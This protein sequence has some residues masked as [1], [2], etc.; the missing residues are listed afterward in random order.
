[1]L[2]QLA[3]GASEEQR[4]AA[5]FKWMTDN[6]LKVQQLGTSGAGGAGSITGAT[7]TATYMTGTNVFVNNAWKKD[8]PRFLNRLL[9][10][11]LDGQRAMFDYFAATFD[12]V[13]AAAKSEGE[14]DAGIKTMAAPIKVEE[15]KVLHTDV[16]SREWLV[17]GGR[18]AQGHGLTCMVGGAGWVEDGVRNGRHQSCWEKKSVV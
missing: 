18:G 16:S 4:Q 15:R 11:E 2:L 6:M 1:V 12:A 13:V 9:G 14:Y 5:F 17:E 7:A 8:V 10:L 3:P